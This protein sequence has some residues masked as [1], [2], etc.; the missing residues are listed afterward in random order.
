MRD[1]QAKRQEQLVNTEAQQGQSGHLAHHTAANA[2]HEGQG[3]PCGGGNAQQSTR[4]GAN[5][6]DQQNWMGRLANRTAPHV[7]HTQG[8][9]AAVRMR[10][11][12]ANN[13]P[14][15]RDQNRDSTGTQADPSPIL[16]A[17]H[18]E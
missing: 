16:T 15:T 13:A 11:R 4:D 7:E 6:A 17:N 3:A 5:D 1:K 8:H 9:H 10:L 2:M 14:M 18:H 12:R